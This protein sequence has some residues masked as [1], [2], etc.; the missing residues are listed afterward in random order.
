VKG[1]REQKERERRKKQRKKRRGKELPGVCTSKGKLLSLETPRAVLPSARRTATMAAAGGFDLLFK[2]I[3]IGDAAVGKS[4]L[5]H[6]FI[7]D[8]CAF[9]ASQ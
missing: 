9:F 3:I 2:F 7:D 4:C 5:L 6:R 8:E 1:K